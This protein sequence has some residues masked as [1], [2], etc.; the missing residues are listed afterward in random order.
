MERNF[1]IYTEVIIQYW[2]NVVTGEQDWRHILR[3]LRASVKLIKIFCV[4]NIFLFQQRLE[5]SK[6][7]KSL[8]ESLQTDDK[9]QQMGLQTNRDLLRNQF[10]Q[11]SRVLYNTHKHSIQNNS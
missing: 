9:I 4:F 1:G 5:T 8:A 10:R 11:S 7:G 3:L 2:Y 6:N